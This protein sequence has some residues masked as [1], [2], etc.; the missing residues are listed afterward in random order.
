MKEVVQLINFMKVVEELCL[1]TR[2]N[3]MT[4]DRQET[5]SDHIV[6]L[7]YLVMFVAPYLKVQVDYTKMLELALIHDLVEARAGDVSLSA[8]VSNPMLIEEKKQNEMEAIEHF[9]TVLPAPLDEKVYDLFME[10]EARETREA[11][12]V[13]MLDKLEGT[14]QANQYHDGDIR[15]W[16]DC[17]GGECYYPLALKKREMIAELDEE[18]L[19][20]LEE[21]IMDISRSNIEKW[22]IECK[23]II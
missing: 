13:A 10:Y 17:E 20:G 1:V 4:N 11:K 19:T 9:K 18:V 3:L 7:A 23:A 14:L 21:A 22:H 5:D 12:I 16:A 2:D 8:Q 15:Y 6:K